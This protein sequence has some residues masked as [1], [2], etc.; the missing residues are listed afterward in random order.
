MIHIVKFPNSKAAKCT[1][2]GGVP[3][4]IQPEEKVWKKEESKTHV[5]KGMSAAFLRPAAKLSFSRTF[6]GSYVP[7]R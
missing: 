4:G 6:N 7:S 2:I 1:G 3:W 5:K